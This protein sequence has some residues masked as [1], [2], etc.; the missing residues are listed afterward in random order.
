MDE[1]TIPVLYPQY[2]PQQSILRPI[3]P[4]SY[5]HFA[6][7]FMLLFLSGHLGL[8]PG[9]SC[10]LPAGGLAF[11]PLQGGCIPRMRSP[12]CEDRSHPYSLFS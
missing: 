11:Q 12:G 2:C 9:F 6:Y 5:E 4:V 7:F 10:L 1:C 3:K 8:V